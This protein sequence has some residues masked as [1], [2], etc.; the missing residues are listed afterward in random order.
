L[1]EDT[2]KIKM[3][4]TRRGSEDGFAVRRFEKG[5]AYD[6]ADTL[7]RSFLNAGWAYNAESEDE[8]AGGL[9]SSD[10]VFGPL[11]RANSDFNRLFRPQPS[12][13]TGPTN[14]ATLIAKGEL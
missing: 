2:V 11:A 12:R 1:Q 3:L 8:D 14:P 9:A 6:V 4:E 13:G 7:A 5:E 10:L